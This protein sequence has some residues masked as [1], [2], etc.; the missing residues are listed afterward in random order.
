[1]SPIAAPSRAKRR[2]VARPTPA[3]APV[4]TTT[5]GV[6]ASPD[7]CCMMN[8]TSRYRSQLVYL[9]RLQSALKNLYSWALRSLFLFVRQPLRDEL[10]PR[11]FH[12][13]ARLAVA[14]NQ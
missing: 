5:S 14:F 11:I 3:D 1:M 10:A 2:A 8:S 12:H 13:A 7:S 9:R 4:K 6:P